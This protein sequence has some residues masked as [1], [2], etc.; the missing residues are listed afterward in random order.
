MRGP[1]LLLLACLALAAQARAENLP[2]VS[3]EFGFRRAAFLARGMAARPVGMGE[4]FTAVADDAS[5]I[6]WNP[7][8]LG[9]CRNA[10][11]QVQYDNAGNG[12]SLVYG[13]VAIPVARQTL[14]LSLTSFSYGSYE[15]RD[16]DG[17]ITGTRE[18]RDL[19][20]SFSIA[21][22]N[23]PFLGGY[24]G[25]AIERVDEAVGGGA[26]YGVSAGGLVP[27]APGLRAGWAVLH[28]GTKSAGFSLP[29]S[30]RAGLAWLMSPRLR[31]AAEGGYG[32][33]DKSPRVSL[34]AELL[35]VKAIA[36]RMGY[37]HRGK[38]QSLGGLTGFGVGAG[39]RAGRF[40]LDYAY[41]PFG[42]LAVSH[43]FAFLYG[44][45]PSA[46]ERQE[47]EF[48]EAHVIALS[49]LGPK[50]T[51]ETMISAEL[52]RDATQALR[53]ASAA[54]A[55]GDQA[56]AVSKATD[57]IKLNPFYWEAWQMKGNALHAQG[58]TQGAVAAFKKSLELHPDNP[59]LR[60]FLT[61][62]VPA[63]PPAATAATK[64]SSASSAV[65]SATALYVAGDIDGAWRKGS[66]VLTADRTNWEAW[67]LVG[68]C[69]LAK[70]DK[71]AALVSYRESL[72]LHPDNPPLKAYVDQLAR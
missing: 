6:S 40:G 59:E 46:V 37:G 72:R 60:T 57:A 4:A 51:G 61:R 50:R 48:E 69:Q 42:D 53:D 3:S 32:L 49:T 66:A 55:A 45:G 56:T 15:L 22:A 43:R 25:V 41:Q 31:V 8:G 58:D 36:L 5:A 17:V 47:A 54:F 12:L 63:T 20:V 18:A 33:T 23:P 35:P 65:A 44:L 39:V 9:F 30:V 11:G 62:I 1:G 27:V 38:D 34:G 67:Q 26:L 19:A 10:E 28:L 29:G 64:P 13:A 70:G 7:G 68:N 21:A 71:S 2:L 52:E 24:T 16:A 14:G